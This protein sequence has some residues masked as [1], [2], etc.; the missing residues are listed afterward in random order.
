MEREPD[1]ESGR[2]RGVKVVRS[3]LRGAAA[4]RFAVVCMATI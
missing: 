2:G 1:A 4:R 3:E